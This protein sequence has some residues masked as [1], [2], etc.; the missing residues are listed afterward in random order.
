MVNEP[1]EPVTSSPAIPAFEKPKTFT[2]AASS[3]SVKIPSFADMGKQAVEEAAQ[4]DDPYIKG[5]DKE[6]FTMDDFLKCWSDYTDRLKAAGKK[7]LIAIFTATPPVMLE[8]YNF[9]VSISNKSQDNTFRDEK[10][11]LLNY[12]RTTLK[13]FDISIQTRVDDQMVSKRPYTAVEK[14]QHMASK[15]P[16]LVELRKRFNLELE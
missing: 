10:P 5:T 15:N 1:A 11:D 3:T 12:L 4:E 8:P 16:E 9:E 7:T 2:P 13:N 6:D 14:F